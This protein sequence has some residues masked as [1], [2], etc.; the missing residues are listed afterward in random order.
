MIAQNIYKF[1]IN[2]YEKRT[3][4]SWSFTGIIPGCRVHKT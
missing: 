3:A 4:S 2:I 1:E